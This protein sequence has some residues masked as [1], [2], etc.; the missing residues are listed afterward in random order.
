[1]QMQVGRRRFIML[2]VLGGLGTAILA[3]GAQGYYPKLQ[4]R[5]RQRIRESGQF[6]QAWTARG[7]L[8]RA[9]LETLLAA[10][11]AII[12]LDGIQWAHYAAYF[13]WRARE[14]RGY[15]QLY[16][17]L[18]SWLDQ[19]ASRSYGH[20]FLACDGRQ[21]RL[22]VESVLRYRG[23]WIGRLWMPL[24]ERQYFLFDYYFVRE[25]FTLL[26]RTDLWRKLGYDSWPGMLPQSLS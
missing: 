6:P 3:L 9:D 22:V 8:N 7:P 10:S 17:Q 16:E 19:S 5:F 14:L 23:N 1:M 12:A 11:K 20:S 13:Q 26:A 24:F 4:V 25:L 2:V 18:G 21:Q 15:K